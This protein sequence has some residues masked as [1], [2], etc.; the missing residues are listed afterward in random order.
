MI[1][2]TIVFRFRFIFCRQQLLYPFFG[3]GGWVLFTIFCLY[4]LIISAMRFWLQRRFGSRLFASVCH[5]PQHLEPFYPIAKMKSIFPRFF[6]RRRC[7]CN[8]YRLRLFCFV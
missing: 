6:R 1:N 4:S 5:I 3:Y 2:A 8:F 7:R